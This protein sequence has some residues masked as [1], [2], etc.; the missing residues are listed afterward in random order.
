[1]NVA[2]LRE[3]HSLLLGHLA[4]WHTV[5]KRSDSNSPAVLVDWPFDGNFFLSH[6]GNLLL[7]VS[8]SSSKISII[9]AF[10]D[11]ELKVYR[12][13]FP[14]GQVNFFVH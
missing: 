12:T 4:L 7:F 2:T 14:A 1:M 13:L 5:D 6:S 10:V 3:K 9:S 11:V 8:T